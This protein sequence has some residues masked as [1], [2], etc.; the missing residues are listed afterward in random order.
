M[1]SPILVVSTDDIRNV[2]VITVEGPLIDP[3]HADTLRTVLPTVPEEF[4]LL[5]DLSWVDQF[6]DQ[7]LDALK[8]VARD[9]S[10]SGVH[11]IVVC[12]S[13]QRRAELILAGLDSHA[14]VVASVEQALP[15]RHRAA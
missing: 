9:A 5:V 7:A 1:L 10:A 3:A 11:L 13:T 14:G 12:S 4:G 8:A 6:S 15:I 2:L